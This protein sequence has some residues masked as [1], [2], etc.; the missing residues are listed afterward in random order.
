MSLDGIKL[1]DVKWD[2][3]TAGP[4]PDNNNRTEVFL[5]GCKKAISGNPCKGCFNSSTWDDSKAEYSHDPIEMAAH[6]NK[7]APNK[8]ITIGGGEPTDQIDNLI[9]LCKEL[10]KYGF[11]IMVYT[12]RELKEIVKKA[13]VAFDEVSSIKELENTNPGGYHVL[14]SVIFP[15]QFRELLKY[16]DILVD[17]EYH[18]EE[19]LYNDNSENDGTFNSIG[20]ANQIVW[21][22]KEYNENKENYMSGI[23]LRDIISLHLQSYFDLG[24]VLKENYET[25]KIYI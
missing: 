18:Q 4:S 10:K 5:L 8:Y 19:R 7:H 17:G 13:H 24:Y 14:E 6:L 2:T 21:D 11:H 23:A 16:I 15:S 25:H 22:V 1:W 9:I 12:W 20:S 3:C